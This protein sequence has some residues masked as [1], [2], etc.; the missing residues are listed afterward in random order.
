M[1][2]KNLT[3][4]RADVRSAILEKT[5]DVGLIPD[6]TDLDRWINAA[7]RAVYNVALKANPRPWMERSGDLEYAAPLSYQAIGAGGEPVRKIYLCR[8]KAGAGWVKVDPLEEGELDFADLEDGVPGPAASS[9]RW[10]VEGQDFWLTPPPSGPAILRLSFV[11]ELPALVVGAPP[12]PLALG[13]RVLGHHDAVVWKAAQLIYAKDEVIQT[14]WDRHYAQAELELK[15]DLAR[16]QG[17]RTRR[18]RRQSHFPNVR[19]R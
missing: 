10:M 2:G 9:S 17:Q 4:L 18:I 1:A 16:N 3:E 14:P 15:R 11:R 8:A 5:S 7:I 19:R 6:D 13:G 12:A